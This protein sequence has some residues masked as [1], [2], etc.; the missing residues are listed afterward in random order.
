MKRSGYEDEF[1]SDLFE[2]VSADQQELVRRRSG[3][4]HSRVPTHNKVVYD[5]RAKENQTGQHADS[6]YFSSEFESGNLERCVQIFTNE[7]DL[8]LTCENTCK[9]KATSQWYYFS[10]ANMKPQKYTFNILGFVKPASLYN[11]GLRP[12]LYSK[13]VKVWSVVGTDVCYFKHRTLK[14][15]SLDTFV[16]SF[17]IEFT[18]SKDVVFFA[19][20]FPFTY[21]DLQSYLD[22]LEAASKRQNYHE[23]KRKV[24]CETLQKRRC[25]V[26]KIK[27]KRGPNDE[28]VRKYIVFTCRVHPGETN[29]SWVLKGVLDFLTSNKSY[30]RDLLSHYSVVCIP[31]LNPDG[32]VV[33]NYRTDGTGY[34]LNRMWKNPTAALHPTIY[35]TKQ[36]IKKL[37][38]K[39]EVSF[40]FDLHGHSRKQNMFAY[41]CPF[42]HSKSS[43]KYIPKH[44][45]EEKVFPYMLAKICTEFSFPGCSFNNNKKK[46]GT[47]RMVNAI[48]MGIPLSY[49]IEA[50]FVGPSYNNS[51]VISNFEL[52]QYQE[53][54]MQICKT[55][56]ECTQPKQT[57]VNAV[58]RELVLLAATGQISTSGC[59]VPVPT[60]NPDAL[61]LTQGP[62]GTSAKSPDAGPVSGSKQR[63]IGAIAHGAVAQAIDTKILSPRNKS[64][65]WDRGE[66]N[67]GQASP[68]IAKGPLA[69]FLNQPIEDDEDAPAPPRGRPSQKTG[70]LPERPMS[71][72]TKPRAL[73]ASVTMSPTLSGAGVHQRARS[74]VAV[75]A[76]SPTSVSGGSQPALTISALITSLSSF[77]SLSPSSAGPASG[78]AAYIASSS[79]ASA[80][81][82]LLCPPTSC[83][84][85]ASTSS[86]SSDTGSPAPAV[87]VLGPSS[88]RSSVA[89][90][91]SMTS[92]GPEGSAPATISTSST[93]LASPSH[94]QHSCPNQGSLS[95]DPGA[96]VAA[97]VAAAAS[98]VVIVMSPFARAAQGNGLC[99]GGDD[100]LSNGSLHS[101]DAVGTDTATGI[102]EAETGCTET[103]AT[104][105]SEAEDG[106]YTEDDDNSDSEEGTYPIP[107]PPSRSV[108][109]TLEEAAR[110]A[111][112]LQE[113][114]G[115]HRDSTSS[116]P[117][118]P[119]TG[120]ASPTGPQSPTR[121]SASSTPPPVLGPA[122]ACMS[123]EAGPP[124]RGASRARGRAMQPIMHTESSDAES[125]R[126]LEMVLHEGGGHPLEEPHPAPLGGPTRIV[127]PR[128]PQP[129][130]SIRQNT[131]PHHHSTTPRSLATPQQAYR[132]KPRGLAASAG[133]AKT[134]K[135]LPVNIGLAGISY[136]PAGPQLA[137]PVGV[138]L[139]P[140]AEDEAAGSTMEPPVEC[141]DMGG[142]QSVGGKRVRKKKRRPTDTIP[143]TSSTALR[144]DPRGH[145]PRGQSKSV[146]HPNPIASS[147]DPR[148]K[149]KD[150]ERE[151]SKKWYMRRSSILLQRVRDDQSKYRLA[152]EGE[153]ACSSDGVALPDSVDPKAYAD[154]PNPL[155]SR[156]TT[157]GSTRPA[158]LRA[159]VSG[160]TPTADPVSSSV[161]SSGGARITKSATSNKRVGS[162][163]SMILE[164][165]AEDGLGLHIGEVPPSQTS[166]P[167]RRPHTARNAGPAVPSNEVLRSSV[168]PRIRSPGPVLRSKVINP[169]SAGV[170]PGT[171]RTFPRSP[172]PRSELRV[173][174]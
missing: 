96:V 100:L 122:F 55:L 81:Q 26:I 9:G 84:S 170:G 119:T 137:G 85:R 29:S 104:D 49:T 160:N 125:I 17:D 54:G 112:I 3:Q 166:D 33:G 47:A 141:D 128:Q 25:D 53:M 2:G 131:P 1:S 41:G 12:Y 62:A 74:T 134:L 69:S 35:Y 32:V 159:L 77:F 70:E 52:V 107:P 80:T 124:L 167:T 75:A 38:Q 63:L 28:K 56:Y 169:E 138:R 46:E 163:P 4:F 66:E 101:A 22:A 14:R 61:A 161:S 143:A 130:A 145:D 126:S 89:S 165:T 48:E 110:R 105:R 20:C 68:V 58:V 39:G 42:K 123:P 76:S 37:M 133:Q 135:Y 83:S 27:K 36:L 118:T 67:S 71:S 111:S 154:Y 152:T 92:C 148:P 57:M 157:G 129:L 45:H 108:R 40:F 78:P 90:N 93:G 51:S 6:L 106:G 174:P 94:V 156:G 153:G 136:R 31:M 91:A 73:S 21:C 5:K 139:A 164:T 95:R 113:F 171:G 103:E 99:P 97:A 44:P 43:T 151:S 60:I 114:T 109:D 8:D 19:Y 149:I 168:A 150:H 15:K 50:S 59:T 13:K 30:S 34:D 162:R 87:P 121:L 65:H 86:R 98:M 23:L 132:T 158:D 142:A 64:H 147:T 146:V 102:T 127:F 7:Y 172:G 144:F 116:V 11:T 72:S 115:L 140:E 16:L 79:S 18:T 173:S 155:R 117:G 88:G 10:V 82:G 24:L 120:G